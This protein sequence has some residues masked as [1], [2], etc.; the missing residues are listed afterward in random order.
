MTTWAHGLLA[1]SI[2][3]PFKKLSWKKAVWW[4]MFPDFIWLIPLGIYL[5]FNRGVSIT[6]LSHA[7]GFFYHLYGVGH[8]LI[9]SFLVIALVRYKT[10]KFPH[11]MLAWPFIHILMDIPG[12]TRFLTPF[13]YPVSKFTVHGL[14]EWW[15][16]LWFTLSWLVP[17]VIIAST[18]VYE[19][20]KAPKP[21][22]SV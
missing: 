21:P 7:P 10:K 11:E 20:M 5:L 12:H 22:K 14:F 15:H 19:K 13:L 8:S 16:P 17:V 6:D 2:Y 18:W 9:L 4:A 1:F 3:R